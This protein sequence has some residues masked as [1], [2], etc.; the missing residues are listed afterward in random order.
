M[1]LKKYAL[2]IIGT[3]L[4]KGIIQDSH[5]KLLSSSLDILGISISRIV[6]IPDDGSISTVL[7][8]LL[9]QA[10]GILCTGG[11]GPTSDDI[12]RD[13]IAELAG[14]KLQVNEEA[15]KG[16]EQL[17]QRPV[18]QTD[19]NYRQILIPEGFSVLPNP[20]G[21]A[22][23][24]F[25]EIQRVSLFCL[26]GPPREM[27]RMLSMEVI[28]RIKEKIR[29]TAADHSAFLEQ[30][31][32]LEAS[33]FM[34]PESKLEEL[35]STCSVPGVVWGTR[36]Q[37]MSISLYLRGGSRHDREKM[38][39]NLQR[40]TGKE[41]VRTGSEG[42]AERLVALCQEKHIQ[43]TFAESCTGGFLGK[44]VTDVPGSSS[45]LWGSFVSYANTAKQK[46][47]QVSGETIQRYGAVSA[48]TAKEMAEGAL[49]NAEADISCAVTG[50]AG[51]GGGTLEKPVGTV[52]FALAGRDRQTIAVK[53]QFSYPRRD[54]IRKRTA[55]AAL[56]MCEAFINRVEVLD[57]VKK[58]QYI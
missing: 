48:E 47:L 49:R 21:T 35:C 2:C 58:W 29:A 14:V 38:L 9:G 26:P 24:F 43:L 53:W 12:T 11:L 7:R 54:L 45:V 3:E 15:K 39:E 36:I 41:L 17:I 52:W 51:P 16:L 50:I 6:I 18:G 42:V 8:E 1:K 32:T 57:R 13:S 23:G 27:E 44:L 37:E 28:P 19:A 31:E 33:S 22:P 40:H 56:L 4:T 46:M 34:I 55:S 10:D 5:A 30:L 20:L 25:G